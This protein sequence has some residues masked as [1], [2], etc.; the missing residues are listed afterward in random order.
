MVVFKR[1]FGWAFVGLGMVKPMQNNLL[2]SLQ[3]LNESAFKHIGKRALESIRVTEV[4]GAVY[5]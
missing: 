4:K 1:G 5:L 2:Y 3:S